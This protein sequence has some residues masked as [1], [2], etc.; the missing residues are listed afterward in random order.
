MAR[1]VNRRVH[2]D[3]AKTDITR[4]GVTVLVI[5]HDMNFIKNLRRVVALDYG[6]RSEGTFSE[7]GITRRL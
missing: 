3:G 7:V 1:R 5:E 2:A 6:Q 4:K